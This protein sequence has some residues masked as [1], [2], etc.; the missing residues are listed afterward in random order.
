M[1]RIAL[2]VLLSFSLMFGLTSVPNTSEAVVVSV[3]PSKE[4]SRM[5]RGDLIA[6]S[7]LGG[8]LIAAGMVSFSLFHVGLGVLILQEDGATKIQFTVMDEEAAGVLGLTIE[9]LAAYNANV[10]I[11]NAIMDELRT[12]PDETDFETLWQQYASELSWDNDTWN[13][14]NKVSG[15]F[16]AIFL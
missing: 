3:F 1:K 2:N 11:F 5:P 8:F 7:G 6:M 16:R 15:A 9:E 10:D 14:L 4:T 13:A 12:L